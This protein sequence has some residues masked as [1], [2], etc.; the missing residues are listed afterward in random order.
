MAGFIPDSLSQDW[1]TPTWILDAVRAAFGVSQIDLDP[2]SNDTSL[3]NARVEYKVP[4]NDGLQDPWDFQTIFVNP[5][6][7]TSKMHRKDPLVLLRAE[8][9]TQRDQRLEQADE[10]AARR[11][12]RHR[13]R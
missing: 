6:F 4:Q 2:C 5:P 11:V 7:G 9:R 10:G 12:R 13:H 1:C 8:A 3:V